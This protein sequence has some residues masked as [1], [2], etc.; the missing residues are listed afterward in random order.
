[1]SQQ[2]DEAMARLAKADEFCL[3]TAT[4][5][6]PKGKVHM[7]MTA[8]SALNAFGGF[9]HAYCQMQ[10]TVHPD[11]PKMPT[12]DNVSEFESERDIGLCMAIA[13]IMK[14][15]STHELLNLTVGLTM[16][17]ARAC[18]VLEPR[19]LDTM[20][21]VIDDIKQLRTPMPNSDKIQ[22]H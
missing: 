21:E 18:S 22:L 2:R 4:D 3:L 20:Q 10:R 11:M 17:V 13:E 12:D 19:L 9:A 6:S 15:S 7:H 14:H 5:D 16:S 1:M 8:E